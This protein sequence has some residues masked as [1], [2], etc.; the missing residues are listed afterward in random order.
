MSTYLNPG[1]LVIIFQTKNIK[2][3]DVVVFE[4]D[5]DFYI[6]RL[7]KIENS[8]YFLEGDNKKESVDS[9]EFGWI[10]KENIVGKVVYKI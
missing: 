8:K 5:G 2:K 7:T 6:K 3:N 4:R 9:K 1:D 10:D